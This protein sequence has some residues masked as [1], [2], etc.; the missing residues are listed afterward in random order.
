MKLYTVVIHYLQMCD[1]HGGIWLLS[2]I[3]KGG[4]FNLYSEIHSVWRDGLVSATP[5]KRFI[6]FK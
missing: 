2:K 5:P 6:G 1:V 3:W 4:S